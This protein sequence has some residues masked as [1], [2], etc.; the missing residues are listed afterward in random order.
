MYKLFVF[1]IDSTLYDE[2]ARIYPRGNVDALFLLQSLGYIVVVA[3][4]RSP[5]K[6]KEI[7]SVGIHPDFLISNNGHCVFNKEGNVILEKKISLELSSKITEYCQNNNLGLFWSYYEKSYVYNTATAFMP[8]IERN[9]RDTFV[10][11]NKN[12]HLYENPLGGCVAGNKKELEAFNNTFKGKVSVVS[13]NDQYGDI[14]LDECSKWKSLRNLLEEIS[15]LPSECMAFGDN[16]N[17]A[18]LIKS[19]G[20]GVSMGNGTSELKRIA[21]YITT[22]IDKDGII[23]ALKCFGVLNNRNEN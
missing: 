9:P 16:M 14:I 3:T 17:D 13:I 20:I 21:D 4:G 23:N 18:E 8:I 6:A 7:Y 19:C 1:D 12:I 10:F 15:I 2:K 11:D 22:D 5:R